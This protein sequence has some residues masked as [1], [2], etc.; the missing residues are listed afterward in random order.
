MFRGDS[1]ISICVHH[2]ATMY[3]HGI[4]LVYMSVSGVQPDGKRLQVG[5]IE[6]HDR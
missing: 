3:N 5:T 2:T 6:R 4:D 1:V